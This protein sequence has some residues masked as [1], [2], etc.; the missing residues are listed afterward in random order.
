[1]FLDLSTI[2]KEPISDAIKELPFLGLKPYMNSFYNSG[3]CLYLE[4]Q[5]VQTC[6]AEKWYIL[7]FEHISNWI[8]DKTSIGNELTSKEVDISTEKEKQDTRKMQFHFKINGVDIEKSKD[9]VSV[10]Q[11]RRFQIKYWRVC[12]TRRQRTWIL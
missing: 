11:R 5:N 7:Y 8:I 2:I 6:I 1:M 4:I 12:R 10:D 3:E 9:I